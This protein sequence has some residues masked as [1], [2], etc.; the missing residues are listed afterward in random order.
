MSVGA[1]AKVE[2]RCWGLVSVSFREEV[3]PER[4]ADA[5]ASAMRQ[6]LPLDP[7]RDMGEV[8]AE[9]KSQARA[10]LLPVV[11]GPEAPQRGTWSPLGLLGTAVHWLATISPFRL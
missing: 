6:Q 3:A 10:I 4:T 8:L 1:L 2:I 11:R 5:R 7:Q 9:A